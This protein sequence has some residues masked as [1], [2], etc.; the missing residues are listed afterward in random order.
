MPF[1][2]GFVCSA[3]LPFSATVLGAGW[4]CSG[5]VVGLGRAGLAALVY[6]TMLALNG[7]CALL[8]PCFTLRL[9]HST[10][11]LR[12]TWG[13]RDSLFCSRVHLTRV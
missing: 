8:L 3:P 7:G 2:R 4:R 6:A 1:V 11:L 9:Q 13:V 10:G 5:D 12:L